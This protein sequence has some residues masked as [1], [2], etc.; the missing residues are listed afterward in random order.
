MREEAGHTLKSSLQHVLRLDLLNE[1]QTQG[2]D[3]RLTTEVAGSKLGGCVNFF[4]TVLDL[5]S[6]IVPAAGWELAL[7]ARGGV[8]LPLPGFPGRTA[9][10]SAASPSIGTA[11]LA[12]PTARHR[13]SICD[14]FFLG[15]S[16]DVR[17]FKLNGIGPRVGN[18]ALGGDAFWAAA[19][20]LYSPFPYKPWR[21][22]FGSAL[23]T[24]IFANAGSLARMQAGGL[25]GTMDVLLADPSASY[26]IGLCIQTALC[27]LE[28]NYCQ[29]VTARASDLQSPGLNVGVGLSFL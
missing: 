2:S 7:S 15:G 16:T 5:S 23:R 12:G 10:V 21:D 4:K 18:D 17:G 8:L 24:H 27:T 29:P 9:S 22:R 11:S 14:R 28:I 26:G 3:I 6:K 13:S 20:H 19:V 1:D 25:R